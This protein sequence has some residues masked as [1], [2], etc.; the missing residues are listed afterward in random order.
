MNDQRNNST[1][2]L[3]IVKTNS[4]KE[5]STAGKSNLKNKMNEMKIEN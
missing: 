2:H 3:N 5:P 4:A 1:G